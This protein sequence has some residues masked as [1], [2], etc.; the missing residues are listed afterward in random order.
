MKM[1]R[2]FAI[3]T[4]AFVISG[5]VGC[6]KYGTGV[7]TLGYAD[8]GTKR[9]TFILA[10]DKDPNGQNSSQIVGMEGDINQQPQC[11]E[12]PVI[13]QPAQ[14]QPT[15]APYLTNVHVATFSSASGD[16]WF[17]KAIQGAIGNALIATAL[18]IAAHQM[19]KSTGGNATAIS[20]SSSGSTAIVK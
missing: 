1:F 17:N 9:I 4:L 8:V 14:D 3:V 7:H 20:N 6:A 15:P 16:G 19:P 10:K 13:R 11:A 5:L 12:I 2:M 18:P